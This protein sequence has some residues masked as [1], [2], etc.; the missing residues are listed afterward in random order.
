MKLK[1]KIVSV[2]AVIIIG[3]GGFIG[4]NLHQTT[5]F[6]DLLN[7]AQVYTDKL[8]F[9]NAVNSYREAYKIKSDK[10]LI[11]K[12][13]QVQSAKNEKDNYLEASKQYKAGNY[14]KAM[15]VYGDI[16]NKT[17]DS[18]YKDLKSQTQQCKEKYVK[19]NQ[20]KAKELYSKGYYKAAIETADSIIKIDSSDSVS[21]KIKDDSNSKLN[22][23]A[24]DQEMNKQAVAVQAPS[25]QQPSLDEVKQYIINSVFEGNTN[26]FIAFEVGK[27]SV[28]NGITYY[29][30]SIAYNTKSKKCDQMFF[31]YTNK[32]IVRY[33]EM[34]NMLTPLGKSALDLFI[35]N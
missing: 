35:V 1:I 23:V 28:V 8:D 17:G 9:E 31:D 32:K 12:V 24:K 34:D 11:E 18:I 4:Y 14:L 33:S 16:L 13:N 26:Q 19:E 10:S 22:E 30:M 3:I 2:I 20:L 27:P 6:N 15:E 25:N 5:K 7:Q 29:P 21:K